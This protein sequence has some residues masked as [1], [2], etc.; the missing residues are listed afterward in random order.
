MNCYGLLHLIL[1]HRMAPLDD[2]GMHQT[3]SRPLY[4]NWPCTAGALLSNR[5]PFPSCRE[6]GIE[7]GSAHDVAA[8]LATDFGQCLPQ[9]NGEAGLYPEAQ[10]LRTVE[11]IGQ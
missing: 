2:S 8:E 1:G 3:S 5:S 4:M 7:T 10:D 9:V 6:L 11:S